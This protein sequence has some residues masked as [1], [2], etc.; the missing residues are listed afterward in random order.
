MNQFQ[1]LMKTMKQT[2]YFQDLSC[3]RASSVLF[4]NGEAHCIKS[5][6]RGYHEY[7]SKRVNWT[8]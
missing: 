7:I 4:D 1:A 6:I 2:P 8:I 3:A 5:M